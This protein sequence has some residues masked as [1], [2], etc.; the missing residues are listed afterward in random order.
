V[1][2]SLPPP[3]GELATILAKLRQ[4]DPAPAELRA[5]ARSRLMAAVGLV[6]VAP[7]HGRTAL[8]TKVAIASVAF[9]IGGVVGA[10]AYAV[11]APKPRPQVVYVDRPMAPPEASTVPA[12]VPPPATAAPSAIAT[13][14]VVA[15]APPARTSQLSAERVILDE[16]RAA[17]A[18]GDPARA[19]DRLERHRRSFA[20]PI[21]GEER[22]AMRVEALAKA[23][24]RDDAIAAAAA[25]HKR[26]PES[27][28]AST[29]DDAASSVR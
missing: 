19:L 27:L 12:P 4:A 3:D 11:F 10:V 24:R 29:V 18:Q 5:R 13:S 9:L 25:F 6:P 7:A 22:D 23:G 21:L 2:E 17:L 8:S 26:W 15:S 28:F 14:P 1:S 20:A 16:A